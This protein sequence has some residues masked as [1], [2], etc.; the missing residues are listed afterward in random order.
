[1]TLWAK[2]KTFFACGSSAAVRVENDGGTAAWGDLGDTKCAG[3]WMASTTRVM[4]LL[5]SSFEPLV[6]GYQKTSLASVSM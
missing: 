3:T 5:E 1:M 2:H 6:A 4:A